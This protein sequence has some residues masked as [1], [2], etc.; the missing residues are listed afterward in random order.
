MRDEPRNAYL[1]CQGWPVLRFWNHDV[2]R[3]R[4]SIMEPD[5]CSRRSS[6]VIDALIRPGFA[7]HLLPEGEGARLP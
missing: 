5:P 1:A 7:G 2:V 3:N 4:E 6:L